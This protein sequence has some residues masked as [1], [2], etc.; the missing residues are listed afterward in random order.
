MKILRSPAQ[1]SSA[2]AGKDCP[3]NDN[4]HR[5]IEFPRTGEISSQ[6]PDKGLREALLPGRRQRREPAGHRSGSAPEVAI[7]LCLLQ[8]NGRSQRNALPFSDRDI[9]GGEPANKDQSE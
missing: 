9:G 3:G 4:R 7:I 5:G 6:F 8:N 1:Q 2:K